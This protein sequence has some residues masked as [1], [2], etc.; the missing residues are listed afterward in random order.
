MHFFMK[1]DRQKI[2]LYSEYVKI[3]TEF[4]KN[5][6]I[7]ISQVCYYAYEKWIHTGKAKKVNKIRKE[8]I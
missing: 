3:R 8:I 1:S 6:L 4:T 5:T 2:Q 7:F